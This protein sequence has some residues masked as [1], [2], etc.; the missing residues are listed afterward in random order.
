MTTNFSEDQVGERIEAMRRRPQRFRDERV[1]MAHGAGGKASRAL[2]EGLVVPLLANPALEAL[3]DAGLLTVGNA[4]SRIKRD[5]Y[6]RPTGLELLDPRKVIPK[7]SSYGKLY[8]DVDGEKVLPP[9]VLHVAGVGSNGIVGKSVNFTPYFQLEPT[10]LIPLTFQPYPIVFEGFADINSPKGKDG[11]GYKT[12]TEILIH[13]DFALDVGQ[14][15]MEKPHF[16][17]AFAGFEYWLNKFGNNNGLYVPGG[18]NSGWVNAGSLAYSPF[19]G[20]RVH[21]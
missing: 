19:V 9:D 13:F 14:V 11:F 6:F 15:F 17:E 10:W 1:T 5:S 7:R 12:A 8:Y 20:I 4:Y 16:V 3:S 21:F 2:V 18:F